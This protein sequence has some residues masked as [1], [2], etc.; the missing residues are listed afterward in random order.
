MNKKELIISTIVIALAASVTWNI[1]S[2]YRHDKLVKETY[3]NAVNY[4]TE[5]NYAAA[6]N[7]FHS[8]QS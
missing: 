6:V 2:D 8:L 3:N 4:I 1:Y 7:A 5:E